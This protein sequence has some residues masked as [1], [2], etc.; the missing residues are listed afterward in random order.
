M[1]NVF[2]LVLFIVFK[3]FPLSASK[4]EDIEKDLVKFGSKNCE[5]TDHKLF[6]FP[7]IYHS[8][9]SFGTCEYAFVNNPQKYAKTYYH[10]LRAFA[11][12]GRVPAIEELKLVDKYYLSENPSSTILNF[13]ENVQNEI[14]RKRALSGDSSS[15]MSLTTIK[16]YNLDESDILQLS[17]F[18]DQKLL[19]LMLFEKNKL[20][21]KV[22]DWKIYD[23][24]ISSYIENL[25]RISRYYRDEIARRLIDLSLHVSNEIE[26]SSIFVA[27]LPYHI[28]KKLLV[29]TSFAPDLT[30]ENIFWAL[31][32]RLYS[33]REKSTIRYDLGFKKSFHEKINL[34]ADLKYY[35]YLINLRNIINGNEVYDLGTKHLSPVILLNIKNIEKKYPEIR[36]DYIKYFPEIYKTEILDQDPLKL[37][38]LFVKYLNGTNQTLS[39]LNKKML[40]S[41]IK[42]LSDYAYLIQFKKTLPYLKYINFNNQAVKTLLNNIKD[43]LEKISFYLRNAKYYSSDNKISNKYFYGENLK[44]IK[45]NNLLQSISLIKDLKKNFKSVCLDKNEES[46]NLL[47]R[48]IR[49]GNLE[50]GTLIKSFL[51]SGKDCVLKKDFK[52]FTKKLAQQGA[53]ISEAIRACSYKKLRSVL[54]LSEDVFFKQIPYYLI[55]LGFTGG[56][57]FAGNEELLTSGGGI[58]AA[59]IQDAKFD[60]RKIVM[61]NANKFLGIKSDPLSDRF[62]SLVNSLKFPVF[63]KSEIDPTNYGALSQ[64]YKIKG[65]YERSLRAILKSLESNILDGNDGDIQSQFL[66]VGDL[67]TIKT[68]LRNLETPDELINEYISFLYKKFKF[69][70]EKITL[71]DFDTGKA[72]IK[73]SQIKEAT[74]N[75]LIPNKKNDLIT[76]LNNL[77]QEKA[78]LFVTHLIGLPQKKQKNKCEDKT[79]RRKLIMTSRESDKNKLYFGIA[80][81]G[82]DIQFMSQFNKIYDYCLYLHLKDLSAMK[83]KKEIKKEFL[84]KANEWKNLVKLKFDVTDPRYFVSIKAA[85]FLSSENSS[86]QGILLNSIN[87]KHSYE[88][89]AK[90]FLLNN[91]NALRLKQ[92][93]IE[94]I[95]IHINDFMEKFSPANEREKRIYNYLKTNL[96]MIESSSK[97]IISSN[98]TRKRFLS[99][100]GSAKEEFF[101]KTTKESWNYKNYLKLKIYFKKIDEE[102]ESQDNVIDIINT[103]SKYPDH[104]L[105]FERDL[106]QSYHNLDWIIKQDDFKNNSVKILSVSSQKNNILISEVSKSETYKRTKF[107]I[108]EAKLSILKKAISSKS[109]L[110]EDDFKLGCDLFSEIHK[111]LNFSKNK[112]ITAIPSVNLFPIPLSIVFGTSCNGPNVPI[113]YASD[114]SSA[115]EFTIFGQKKSFPTNFVGVGNPIL[116]K[117]TFDI[118]IPGV[119]R[120][121]SKSLNI[122]DFDIPGVKKSNSRDLKTYDFTPLPEASEEI[123][124]ISDY[125]SNKSLFLDEKAS[126]S[127]ALQTAENKNYSAIVLATHGVPFDL[128]EGYKLPSLLSIENNNQTL[129]SASK[130]NKYDLKQST[131]FLSACDSASGLLSDP[132]LFLTGFTEAFA[133]AGSNLIVASLW[134]VVSKS[135]KNYSINFFNGWK[136]NNLINGIK[137]AE[138]SIEKNI[139][140]LPFITIYP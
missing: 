55:S 64:F 14:T 94:T 77:N 36:S 110:A 84:L 95:I 100:I 56:K 39:E 108:D 21:Q 135:S 23:Q 27:S 60:E 49:V 40:L 63:Y 69:N 53:L 58:I 44:K 89:L 6:S 30:N 134:P 9:L 121:N 122:I 131:V 124:D 111:T 119:K 140:K 97:I 85:S 38:D 66:A 20:N 86:L 103:K 72:L 12:F 70:P 90:S 93:E 133:N 117:D 3:C 11:Y 102:L 130:I 51:D 25:N 62:I 43:P 96:N 137:E 65:N 22:T 125:F 114:I 109:Y 54:N 59:A 52:F 17:K 8:Q 10:H 99:L 47:W 129:V 83:D 26:N 113:I 136:K 80:M 74:R 127:K 128:V 16:N 35:S 118:D 132:T 34:N 68:L 79:F 50:Y 42:V 67:S 106:Y 76:Y 15:L 71:N 41:D 1:K 48:E 126:I 19:E 75:Y 107:I 92:S 87:L 81:G 29:I 91:S 31:R 45:K 18:E 28:A 73:G 4:L 37:N 82:I 7:D 138:K 101:N 57:S 13:S 78:I 61:P 46:C 123:I 115:V 116:I 33:P 139:N 32:V 112:F 120:S 5:T 2:V 24:Y 105:Y 98:S 104:G 88:T